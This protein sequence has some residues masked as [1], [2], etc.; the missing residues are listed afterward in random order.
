MHLVAPLAGAW[1]EIQ[2]R[3][4]D[5]SRKGSLLSRERGLKSEKLCN[6]AE[7][8]T[9]LLSRERGLK[10]YRQNQSQIRQRSLLSRER[11]LK[12]RYLSME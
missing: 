6:V 7:E 12:Y 5:K 3:V 9:S 11:G 10:F 2:R 8:C 1:I 4:N